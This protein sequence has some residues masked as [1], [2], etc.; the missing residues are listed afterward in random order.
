MNKQIGGSI[1]E[2]LRIGRKNATDAEEIAAETPANLDA[3]A[4]K[5]P[6]GWNA[7]IGEN[8]CVLSGGQS[9]TARNLTRES[10]QFP[11]AS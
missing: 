9:R 7:I 2:S 11:D 5:L 6:D 1:L 4:E 10:D 3:F 8:G